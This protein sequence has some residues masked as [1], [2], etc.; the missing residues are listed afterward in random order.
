MLL[1]SHTALPKSLNIDL[2]LDEGHKIELL[3]FLCRNSRYIETGFTALNKSKWLK[4][5][6]TNN[7]LI[8][9][10]IF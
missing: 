9:A 10:L 3:Q 1:P 6:V 4:I 2:L 8:A 7:H 5:H